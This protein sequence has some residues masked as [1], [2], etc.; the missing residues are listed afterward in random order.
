[1]FFSQQYLDE[2]RA[3]SDLL[4]IVGRHVP[5]TKKGKRYWA[6]CPFHGEKTASFTVDPDKQ[7]Y[8]C[9]GCHAAGNV[10]GFMMAMHRLDFVDAVKLLAEQANMPLPEVEDEQAYRRERAEKE[11]LYA[12]N[13]Q[14]A[15]FYF[16]Q[17][18]SPVGSRARAY[19]EKRGITER[20]IRR[21]GLGYAPGGEALCR[22]LQEQGFTGEQL[23][24]AGLSRT[25]ERGDYD[26]FRDRVMYP[27]ID[28]MGR[29]VGFG[30]RVMGDA[31]PKY[32]NTSD[33]PIFNKRHHL[34]GIPLL[35]KQRDIARAIVVEGYMDVIG[36]DTAGVAGAVASLG[37]ALTQEQARL[38]RR[39]TNQVLIAYDGDS[40]G[41]NAMVRGLDILEGQGLD[42]R[43][44]VLPD[45]QDPDDLARSGGQEAFEALAQKA[46]PLAVFKMKRAALEYD[47]STQ[48]GRTAYAMDASKILAEVKNPIERESY[49]KLLQV[50]TGFSTQALADQ[51]SVSGNDLQRQQQQ[52]DNYAAQRN[53]KDG[54]SSHTEGE[55]G[56]DYAQKGILAA[57]LKA[58]EDAAALMALIDVDFPT[59]QYA[60]ALDVMRSM[61]AGGE[62]LTSAGVSDHFLQAA[63]DNRQVLELLV[64]GHPVGDNLMEFVRQAVHTLK[65]QLLPARIDALMI[66]ASDPTIDA[67]ERRRIVLEINRLTRLNAAAN[68]ARTVDIK[69]GGLP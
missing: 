30:G 2:L 54:N 60:K 44:V 12:A 27:I 53:N 17:L 56:V 47:L 32:L 8:Y 52:R 28:A 35:K 21:F 14:A 24:M 4:E 29:V 69:E 45:G 40:A 57:L 5:L 11:R 10:I 1:M 68:A 58:G 31:Q 19:L 43:V 16:E 59:P 18:F 63:D 61:L 48:Q 13:K 62:P 3:R 64:Q 50:E 38:I 42:V 15:R 7:M 39:Y 6:C 26:Q 66:Q 49:L 34:Y 25:G 36:L 20:A 37:T 23:A 22:H 9:F 51:I 67:Q 46:L 55:Q 41:Q 33:T 65:K